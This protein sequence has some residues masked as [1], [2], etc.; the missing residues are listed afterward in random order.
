MSCQYELKL[1]WCGIEVDFSA[2]I[3]TCLRGYK[4][5][6]ISDIA[7]YTFKLKLTFRKVILKELKAFYYNIY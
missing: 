7:S 1:I 2:L 5:I 4:A 3:I 6:I